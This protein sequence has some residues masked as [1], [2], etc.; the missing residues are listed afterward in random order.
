MTNEPGRSDRPV[1]PKKF[2]NNA[3][4]L[5]REEREG[6]G[7]AKGK[8]LRQNASRTPSRNEAAPARERVRQAP[9]K[10]KKLRFTALLDHL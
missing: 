7:L 6:R 10:D 5:A 9:K 4:Q 2:P 8:L 1:V 3:G